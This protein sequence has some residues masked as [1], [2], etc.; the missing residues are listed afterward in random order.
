MAGISANL[1][2]DSSPYHTWS[3]RHTTN[4]R[5]I[6]KQVLLK[7]TEDFADTVGA[8]LWSLANSRLPQHIQLHLA[9]S[10]L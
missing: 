8:A 6:D 9:E 3:L 10:L 5:G 1:T 7:I 4:S 2:Y